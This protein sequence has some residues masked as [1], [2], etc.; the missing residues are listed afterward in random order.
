MVASCSGWV[1]F[2]PAFSVN[3]SPAVT[4]SSPGAFYQEN[5]VPAKETFKKSLAFEPF[6]MRFEIGGPVALVL[7]LLSPVIDLSQRHWIRAQVHTGM[8]I[9]GMDFYSPTT[10]PPA[11]PALLGDMIATSR[12]ISPPHFSAFNPLLANCLPI[13]SRRVLFPPSM[14]LLDNP[15]IMWQTTRNFSERGAM[16]A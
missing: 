5:A 10:S 4:S 14:P 8:T 6:R 15:D 3:Y 13:A 2:F 12:G 9:R 11:M 1:N 16:N 7:G